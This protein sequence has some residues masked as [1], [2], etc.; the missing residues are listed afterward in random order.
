MY[1]PLL[2]IITLY[3]V[4]AF[5]LCYISFV[6]LAITTEDKKGESTVNSVSRPWPVLK[7]VRA[8]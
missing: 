4:F 5:T 2:C 7:I 8:C 1:S 3:L 6:G